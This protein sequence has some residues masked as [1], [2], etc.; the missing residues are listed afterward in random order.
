MTSS[1]LWGE[2]PPDATPL[3]AEDMEQLLP[4]DVATRA[5]LNAVERDNILAARLWAFT[6]RGIAGVDALF[7]LATVDDIHRRMFGNVWSWAGRRRT[8]V[9]NIGVDPTRIVTQLRNALADAQYWHDNSI[10]DPVERA[11]RIHHRLVFIHPYVNGN[12][13]H[14]RFVAD[15]YLHL[16]GEPT[17][18][19]KPDESDPSASRTAYIAALRKAD[20]G[21]YSQL[22]AYASS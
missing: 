10:F 11:V 6:A 22:I 8:R 4:T 14:A 16:I 7:E 9:T 17:L 2:E 5:D 18:P 13:R 12:G 3:T 20:E 1:P 15:L 19:W 21:E